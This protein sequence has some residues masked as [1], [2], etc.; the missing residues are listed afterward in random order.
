MKGF[1]EAKS[2]LREIELAEMGDMA[3]R[4]LLYLQ[5]HFGLDTLSWRSRGAIVTDVGLSP[6]AIGQANQ[7]K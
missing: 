7:L 5:C 6:V 2:S 1:L 4:S 3:G